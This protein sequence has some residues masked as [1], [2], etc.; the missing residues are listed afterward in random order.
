MKVFTLPVHGS[1]LL[2]ILMRDA[3]ECEFDKNCQSLNIENTHESG[4]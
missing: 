1:I 2:Y 4:I 3:A